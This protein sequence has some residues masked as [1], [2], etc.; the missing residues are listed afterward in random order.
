M[1]VIQ[2]GQ[3]RNRIESNLL[4]PLSQSSFQSKPYKRPINPTTTTSKSIP[5][6]SCNNDNSNWI[7]QALWLSFRLESCEF[8]RS[9]Y[10]NEGGLNWSSLRLSRLIDVVRLLRLHNWQKLA[11]NIQLGLEDCSA[12]WLWPNGGGVVIGRRGRFS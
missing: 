10:P 3:T 6:R 5:C 12:G 8:G 11:G 9:V 7:R 1:P 4:L 2:L